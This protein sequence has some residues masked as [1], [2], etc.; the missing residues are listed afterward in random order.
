MSLN[1]LITRLSFMFHE[2]PLFFRLKLS[3][4][5]FF[6]FGY[7]QPIFL[8]KSPLAFVSY[9]Q[10]NHAHFPLLYPIAVFGAITRVSKLI[11]NKFKSN[12]IS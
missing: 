12:V 8:L 5:L 7:T 2:F 4:Y 1:Y 10:K 6:K 11:I 9:F 3:I